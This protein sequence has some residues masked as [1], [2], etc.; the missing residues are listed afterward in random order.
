MNKEKAILFV[1]EFYQINR[2]IAIEL[3]QDEIE[4]YVQLLEMCDERTNS[5]TC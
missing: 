2:E 5:K 3:Y 4:A 1:M